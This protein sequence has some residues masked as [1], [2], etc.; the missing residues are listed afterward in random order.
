ME[1]AQKLDEL[2]VTGPCGGAA[3]GGDG[4]LNLGSERS[5]PIAAGLPAASGGGGADMFVLCSSAALSP[6]SGL[7]AASCI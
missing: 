5:R 4:G 1:H 6:T 3:H 2:P 7:P